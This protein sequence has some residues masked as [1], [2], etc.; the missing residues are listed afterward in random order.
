MPLMPVILWTDA[1]VFLLVISAIGFGLYAARHEHLRAPWRRV[2]R[3]RV[4]IGTLVV[5]SFYVLIGLLDTV[6]F[7]LPL[8]DQTAGT[9][10]GAG[11]KFGPDVL[12]LFD[13]WAAPLRERQEKTYSAPFATHLFVK[14]AITQP[15]GSVIRDY[16]RLNYGGRHLKDPTQRGWDILRLT[17]RGLAEG[18]IV[19]GLIAAQVVWSTA[20]G[21]GIGFMA[22]R[23]VLLAGGTAFPW[24]TAL[25]T[26]AVMLVLGFVAGELALRYHILGTDK[27]GEDVFFQ[28]LKSIRTGLVIGTLTTLVML[29]AAILLGIM[30]GYFRGWVDDIIQY[31]YTTL[32]AIPGVL[33]IA[34]AILMLQVYMSNN[35]D[36][37]E[38]LVER[39]DLRLLFLCL[40]LGVTSWTGLCRLLRGEALKLREADYV[41]ASSALGVGHFAILG[42]HILPNVLH[43]V[44]ITLVLDFSGLVLAEAVLS[45]VNIGVDPTMNS[46]GNMINSARL[47]LARDPMVWWSL[48]AAFVFMFALV[49]AANLFADVVRDA[50]DPRLRGV[51]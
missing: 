1:L 48:T 15:D 28:A 20:R 6:H 32:N 12:S 11:T 18:L 16:P 7:R 4:G 47:E 46:W 50:F 2:A 30:A 45:Y 22:A 19:W 24:R 25:G 44:M 36:Q 33:L 9:E 10:T 39:A 5:L 21:Q 41:R 8:A 17:L 13:A 35:A 14:E 27:V 23:D 37:F 38:S 40:I 26:L 29:P 51:R 31:L 43:I 34:A 49:L 3:S 42:R